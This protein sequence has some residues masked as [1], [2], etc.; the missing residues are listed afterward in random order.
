M[1]RR[2]RVITPVLPAAIARDDGLA[3]ALWLPEER[4]PVVGGIVILH[5]AGSCKES[6]YDF[7]RGALPLG[8]AVIA[9]DQ[10]GHGESDGAL[11]GAALDDITTMA[12]RL[13]AAVA[14]RAD[15]LDAESVPIAVRGS[16]MGGYFAILAAPAIDAAA[17]VAICPAS[18][19]GLRR[20][21]TAGEFEFRADVES[22]DALLAAH[23]LHDA[24]ESLTTPLLLLHAEGD[25]RVPVE[26]SRELAARASADAECR[27]IAVPGGHHRSVQHDDELRAFS[28][29]WIAQRLAAQT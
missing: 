12:G 14:E 3:Y 6:H 21:L 18:A 9:F 27:L 16:S 5:G 19:D 23:D 20:G 17:I 2:A 24:V 28:L 15:G 10:R 22:L 7:A 1:P 8:L 4:V 25:E 13:R 11:D 29:R 26:H